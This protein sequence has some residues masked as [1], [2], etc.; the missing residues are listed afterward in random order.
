MPVADDEAVR[1]EVYATLR[2][3]GRAPSV[4]E[5]ALLTGMSDDDVQDSLISLAAA[6]ALVLTPAGDAVRMAHPFSAAPMG[7]VV[8]PVDPLD[9]RLWWG[10]CAWDSFGMSAAMKL[11]VVISTRCPQC[12]AEH[13]VLA[14]PERP[15]AEGLVVRFPSPARQWWDDVVATCSAIRLFC[16]DDHGRHWSIE[17]AGGA[18]EV[19]AAGTVWRLAGPWYGDRLAPDFR[20]HTTS[21]NQQLLTD[22]GLTGEFWQLP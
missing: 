1:R 15:P 17:H 20:A 8:A 19:V 11:D 7:F 10:G 16:S 18:G 13:R 3:R 12:G 9:D 6:H 21:Y 2:T 4:H 22:V 14:G 5:I